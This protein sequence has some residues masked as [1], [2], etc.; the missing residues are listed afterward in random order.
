MLELC[1]EVY[2]SLLNERKACYDTEQKTV[3][4]FEQQSH[5]KQWKNSHPELTTVHSQVLQN[6]SVRIDLAFQA[7]FRRIRTGEKA[8]YPRFKGTATVVSMNQRLRLFRV[9][10]LVLM[11]G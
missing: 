11:S 7:F 9:K 1:R 3:S 6:I 5:I 2:N 4:C 8:G 10:A